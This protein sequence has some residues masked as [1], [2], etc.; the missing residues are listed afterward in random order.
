[1]TLVSTAAHFDYS[2]GRAFGDIARSPEAVAGDDE[3]AAE[4]AEDPGNGD[5]A[6]KPTID[7]P[8]APALD[9]TPDEFDRQAEEA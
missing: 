7:E 9:P 1:V 3:R 2:A 8:T 4:P 6:G 5:D